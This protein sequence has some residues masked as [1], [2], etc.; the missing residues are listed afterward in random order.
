[1]PSLFI[2]GHVLLARQK[3]KPGHHKKC[4]DSFDTFSCSVIA[5]SEMADQQPDQPQTACAQGQNEVQEQPRSAALFRALIPT[6]NR[7]PF[8]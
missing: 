4:P 7:P 5:V 6:H 1:M 2:K 8:R 3:E